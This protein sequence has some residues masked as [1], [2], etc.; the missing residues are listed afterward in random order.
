ML[1]ALKSSTL[2]SEKE[3]DLDFEIMLLELVLN[4]IR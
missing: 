1:F 4:K 2:S 3:Y